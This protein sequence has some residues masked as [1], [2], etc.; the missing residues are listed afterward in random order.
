MVSIEETDLNFPI[1]SIPTLLPVPGHWSHQGLVLG[2]K[3]N[4]VMLCVCTLR[5][6]PG[7]HHRTKQ[8]SS[9]GGLRVC[10]ESNLRSLLLCECPDTQSWLPRWL[11]SNSIKSTPCFMSLYCPWLITTGRINTQSQ[12]YKSILSSFCLS[13]LV[14]SMMHWRERLY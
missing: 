8:F 14:T 6:A 11:L 10:L 2:S 13:V 3:R 1:G 4:G 7:K 5:A 9:L 12:G